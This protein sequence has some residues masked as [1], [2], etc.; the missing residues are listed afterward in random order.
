[1]QNSGDHVAVDVEGVKSNLANYVN[2][3][4][5]GCANPPNLNVTALIDAAASCTLLTKTAP[6]TTMTNEDIQI[7]VIQP[8]GY[9]MTTTHAVDLLLWNL[10]P[11]AHLGH[12]LP[13]LVN[14]LLSIAALV[15]T[16]CE[17]FFHP[18]GCE[19]TFDGAII[20]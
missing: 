20:L 3:D 18:T 5:S 8:G 9:R 14:N 2:G 13:G 19:V 11:E 16:G 4:I 12:C 15:D 1:M 6:T 7:T 17:V 10:P